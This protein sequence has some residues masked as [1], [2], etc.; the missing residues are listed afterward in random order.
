MI[1]ALK[2]IP[3]WVWTALKLIVSA[4]LLIWFFAAFDWSSALPTLLTIHPLI[5]LIGIGGMILAQLAGAKRFQ[6]L[7]AAQGVHI[8][9]W[10]SVQ[11]IFVGLF[12]SNFLPSTVGGDLVRIAVL[13][14]NQ[15]GRVKSSVSVI[16]DRLLN[17][18]AVFA[19]LPTAFSL[20]DDGLIESQGLIAILI[21]LA[22][23]VIAGIVALLLTRRWAANRQPSQGRIG[24]I[25]DQV[26]AI[27]DVWMQQPAVTLQS[28]I[29]S[30]ISV[31]SSIIS[32]YVLVRYLNM[33]INFVEFT[34]I[35]VLVYFIS[36]V[37][38]SLG[39]LGVQEVSLTYLLVGVGASQDQALAFAVLSR[40]FYVLPTLLGAFGVIGKPRPASTPST[41]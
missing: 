24:Q 5:F 37:P 34:A 40:L 4:A 19:L 15:T 9:Y 18:L 36:L 1:A 29:L 25:I 13:A 33:P 21:I 11:V 12:A 26:L 16:A 27:L 38:I 23:V 10:Y 28:L 17:V 2:R 3:G 32:Q 6:I 22:I 14:Q 8:S 41:D 39:G 30:W 7:L 31:F 35:I 20:L